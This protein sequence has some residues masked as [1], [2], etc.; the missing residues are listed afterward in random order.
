MTAVVAD[1]PRLWGAREDASDEA[2]LRDIYD[3]YWTSMVRL[4]SLLLNSSNEAE[5]IV[6]D[7]MVALYRRRSQ[8]VDTGSVG[9]YLRTGVVNRCRSVHRHRAVEQQKRHLMVVPPTLPDDG[10]VR[11][12]VSR[13]VIRALHALPDRQREV[14]VLRYYSE[15]SEA[16]I[17]E[18]LGISKGAVKSHARRGMA[19]LRTALEEVR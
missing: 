7:L 6:Q 4:A 14:L 2:W 12:D 3:R 5:E 13:R 19:A 9:G 16:E 17:A 11:A 15:A 8:F 1:M 10:A 18:A